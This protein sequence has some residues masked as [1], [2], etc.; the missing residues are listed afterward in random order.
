MTQ[1]RA[2]VIVEWGEDHGVIIHAD[3]QGYW[4]LPGGKLERT[5]SGNEEEALVAAVR[6][7]RE[8]TGLVAHGALFLFRHTG[9][10]NEHHVFLVQSDGIPTVVDPREAPAIGVVDANLHITW[11]ARTPNFDV[12]LLKPMNSARAVINRYFALRDQHPALWTGLAELET[13]REDGV[14]APITPPP[15]PAKAPATPKPDGQAVQY[16]IGAVVLDLRI[17]DIVVQDVD[18]VVNAANT[19]LTNGAGVSGALHR[20]AGVRNLE[21]ACHPLAPCP[22]GESR[23]TDGFK[24]KARHIIHAVGPVY[25]HTD[26]AESARL[27]ASAYRSSLTLASQHGLHSVAFPSLSTGV[28]GYPV[29]NAAGVALGAVHNFLLT[30]SNVTLVRFVLHDQ[31]SFDAYV[32]AANKLGLVLVE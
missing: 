10:H 2:T 6:E 28:F 25:S 24:L 9:I 21:A 31:K 18:A 1:Q 23:I 14:A 12:S 17:A 19:G 30:P 8:E 32:R 29:E 7:L 26:P 3:H 15:V 5:R 13:I 16:Q 27:L 4:L 11:I 20:G 22:T